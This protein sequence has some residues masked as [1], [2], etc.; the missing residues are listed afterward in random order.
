M[1]RKGR[2][3]RDRVCARCGRNDGHEGPAPVGSMLKLVG[4]ALAYACSPECA[5]ALGW[6]NT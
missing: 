2:V 6:L 1:S 4:D 5:A 3:I